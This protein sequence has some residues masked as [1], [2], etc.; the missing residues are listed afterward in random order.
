MLIFVIEW[1]PKKTT[2]EPLNIKSLRWRNG[3]TEIDRDRKTQT[4]TYVNKEFTPKGVFAHAQGRPGQ[5]GSNQI[6]HIYFLGGLSDIFETVSKLVEG[7]GSDGVQ[8]S[9]FPTDFSIGF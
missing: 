5:M 7:F 9:A 1:D 2:F 4:D 8:M 6:I 3:H